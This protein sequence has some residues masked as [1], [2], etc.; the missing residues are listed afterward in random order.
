MIVQDGDSFYELDERVELHRFSGSTSHLPKWRRA[1]SIMR[2]LS[3]TIRS[4]QPDVT[5]SFG[6]LVSPLARVATIGSGTRFLIFNR[7]SPLRSLNGRAGVINPL[8]YPLADTVVTQTELAK[9]IL[10]RRYRFT[11]FQVIPNPVEIPTSIAPI[12]TRART[13]ISVG[14]LGGQKNQQALLKAFAASRHRDQWKLEI[15]GD[16]PDRPRLIEMSKDLSI[17]DRV[18]FLGER[19]DV[20]ERLADARIFAFTSLAEG[21]PNALSEAL[22]HGCACIAFD[23]ISGPSELIQND[24]NGLLLSPDDEDGYAAALETLMGD[25]ELQQ[26]YSASA[27]VEIGRFSKSAI[28]QCFAE[29][30]LDGAQG[31]R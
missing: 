19:K 2:H 22:A 28:F 11:R 15:V 12:E 24:C 29:L 7:E 14:Y 26:R 10:A 8:T 13:I 5:L 6:E 4:I 25:E 18:E 27:R 30:A 16:G 1:L 17:S 31:S 23:C 20:P 3:A 9:N 21:F